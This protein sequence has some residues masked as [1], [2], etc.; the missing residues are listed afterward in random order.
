M[1]CLH[2]L[3]PTFKLSCSISFYPT[4]QNANLR[5]GF[6]FIHLHSQPAAFNCLFVGVHVVAQVKLRVGW[7]QLPLPS[8]LG[9]SK[10]G[11]ATSRQAALPAPIFTKGLRFMWRAH[12]LI[13]YI[14]FYWCQTAKGSVDCSCYAF[15]DKGFMAN[16][17][18]GVC[19]KLSFTGWENDSLLLIKNIG[20]F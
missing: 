7:H 8:A 19:C 14:I 17:Y 13:S 18:F 3:L 6:L 11:Y 12:E 5:V 9:S 2:P 1:W 10:V 16:S 4:L 15:K 20:I